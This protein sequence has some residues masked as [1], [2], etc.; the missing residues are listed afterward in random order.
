M[1]TAKQTK[2]QPADAIDE[3]VEDVVEQAQDEAKEGNVVTAK[4]PD[5]TLPTGTR[6]SHPAE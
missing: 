2:Q 5:D 3:A 4:E 6:R 1:A